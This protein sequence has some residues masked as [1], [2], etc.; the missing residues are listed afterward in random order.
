MMQNRPVSNSNIEA[1]MSDH[2]SFS[3]D[4][5]QRR[6]GPIW[7]SPGILPRHVYTLFFSGAMAVGFINLLNLIQPLLL[8]EQLGM[9]SGEGDFTAN[10]YIALELTTLIV[11]V[12]LTSAAAVL[13]ALP[14]ETITSRFGALP[15]APRIPLAR[16]LYFSPS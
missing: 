4:S 7:L 3:I 9:T 8:Q 2:R 11:A 5:S 1:R 13:F 10:L 16:V 15:T 14:V 12:G 6:V